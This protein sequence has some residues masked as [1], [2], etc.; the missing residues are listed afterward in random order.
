[1]MDRHAGHGH[2]LARGG[3]F[4][5]FLDGVSR[6]SG[7]SIA[8]TRWPGFG[9]GGPVSKSAGGT[10]D[11]AMRETSTAADVHNHAKTQSRRT[12]GS[13]GDLRGVDDMRHTA[14]CGRGPTVGRGWDASAVDSTIRQV[15]P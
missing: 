5:E 15:S 8:D 3:I 2:G 9:R 14:A 13:P 4:V 10:A 6:P 7:R 1:M 11:A 12:T